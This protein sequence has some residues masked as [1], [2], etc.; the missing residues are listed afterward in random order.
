MVSE[1]NYFWRALNFCFT[2]SASSTVNL[3]CLNSEGQC[4]NI[5]ADDAEI[6][7]HLWLNKMSCCGINILSK[8]FISAGGTYR[9]VNI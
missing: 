4:K 7:H 8:K 3:K 1:L 5:D 2:D 9:T 6:C